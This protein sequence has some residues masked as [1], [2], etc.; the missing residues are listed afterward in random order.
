MATIATQRNWAGE[1]S[2]NIET[3]FA[4]LLREIDHVYN[5]LNLKIRKR[6]T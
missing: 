4:K 3:M 2:Q 6:L 1:V 5:Y